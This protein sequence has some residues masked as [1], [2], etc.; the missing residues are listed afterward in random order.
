MGKFDYKQKFSF[1]LPKVKV[2]T[3]ASKKERVA[4]K[5]KLVK[6]HQAGVKAVEDKIGFA[7]DKAVRS[8]TW[9]WRDGATRD[10]VD[11]GKL[12]RSRQLKVQ[13]LQTKAVIGIQYTAPYATLV[14][15]GGAI[16]PYGNRNAATV[17]IPARPWIDAIF[18]GSYGIEKFDLSKPYNAAFKAAFK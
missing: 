1:A 7:L 6:A 2:D 8:K 11:T 3:K 18:E 15:Y 5:T 16:Q 17:L 13:Y 14:H 9:V 4:A 12:L 10:I